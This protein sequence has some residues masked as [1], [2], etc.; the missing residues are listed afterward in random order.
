MA[1]SKRQRLVDATLSRLLGQAP[2]LHGYSAERVRTPMRD[3]VRLLGDHF[4]P[5][6]DR[7]HGTVLIRT[8]YGR[9]LPTSALNGRLFAARGYHVLLQSVRGT[10]G[11]EGEFTPMAQETE[12]GQD[13]VAWLREQPWFDGRLATLGASYLGWTQW[14]LLQDPPP[15]L[16]AAVIYVGPHDFREAVYGTGSFT[17][18]DFL[19]WSDQIVHQEDG[20]L[21]RVLSLATAQRRLRP[22]LGGLPLAAAAEPVLRGRA[23]WYREW[24]AH[25][26]GDD[27]WWEPYRAGSA[28]TTADVPIL[29][30]GGWQDL[31]LD[32]TLQQ[33]EALHSRGVDVALTVGPWTH[34]Q[35]ALH[36]A[37]TVSRESLA[38][39][40]Q[41]LAGGP[42]ARKSPVRV[43]RT[44]ER[45]W[46]ELPAWPPPSEPVAFHLR[47]G[48]RLTTTGPDGSEG[49]AEFRYDPADPTP[50]AGGRTL[51]G[52]M[53]VKDNRALEARRDVL[54]FTTDPLPTAV[55][56]IGS[57]VLELTVSVDNPHADVF[58]RLCD[59]D[60]AGRSRNF[61]DRHRRL[62]ATLP[63]GARQ[64][65]TLTLDPCFHRL[66]AGH[67]LRLQISGGAFPRFARNPG[68]DDG[69]LAATRHT[70]DIAGS[71]LDLPVA[72]APPSPIRS[73][74]D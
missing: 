69:G 53:G 40:D 23:P 3:G 56:V 61:T 59:V 45:A 36:A 46:H 68:T 22:A 43:H 35:V 8:P 44:G 60:P 15:E 48:R 49:V 34:L 32:Q 41:H 1:I 17:L 65:L 51:T 38:W 19:G 18:G 30:I 14:T 10:F 16:R 4:A 11:S 9:G 12:D 28:L 67:R 13:T 33:Y 62:D 20:G 5:H 52:S 64:R 55:D 74:D 50:S 29:L 42:A 73:L 37:G 63:A 26:D 39:L 24:L 66:L 7:P 58:V 21:R 54:V 25:P 6:T 72:V 57:P 47:A 2:A 71:R 31:F 27:P 70:V